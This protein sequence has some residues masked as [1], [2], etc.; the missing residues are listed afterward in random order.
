MEIPNYITYCRKL[1]FDEKPDYNHLKRMLKELF[2]KEGFE[3]DY[4]YDWVLLPVNNNIY[5]TLIGLLECKTCN[6]TST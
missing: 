1:K 5:E 4:V 6:I 3:Y 2:M